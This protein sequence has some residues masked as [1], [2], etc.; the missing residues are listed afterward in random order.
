MMETAQVTCG[1]S[2]GLCRHKENGGGMKRLLKQYRK[3]RESIETGKK[4]NQQ[5]QGRSKEE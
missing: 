2:K 1:L 5:K 4:K 3:R